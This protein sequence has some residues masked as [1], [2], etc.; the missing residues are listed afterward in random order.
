MTSLSS[1]ISEVDFVLQKSILAQAQKNTLHG[2][3]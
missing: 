2:T 3:G 1:P